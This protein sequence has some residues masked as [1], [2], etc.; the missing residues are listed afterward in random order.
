LK[1]LI[2]ALVASV[3]VAAPVVA[4]TTA[5]R[6]VTFSKDI[7][8]IL[9]RSCQRCHRPESVA[10]MTLMTYE[11]VRPYAREIKR[12]T[13]LARTPW[14]RGAMPPWFVEKN[15]GIQQFKDDVSLTDDELGKIA[16]WADSG[17]PEGDPKDLPPAVDFG[18]VTAWTLGKPDLIVSSPTVVVPASAS[19]WSGPVGRSPTNIKEDRYAKSAEYKEVSVFTSGKKPNG[20]GTIGSLYAIHH[21]NTIIDNNVDQDGNELIAEEGGEGAQATGENRQNIPNHEVGRNGD[22]FPDD[23]GRLIKK[24]SYVIWNNMHLHS[25]GVPG[26]ER[27]TRL[28]LGFKLQ[29]AGYKPKY[30]FLNIGFGRTEIQVNPSEGNQ[31]ED[32][33]FVAPQALKLQNYEPHMHATGVR[34]CLEAIYGRVIETLSCSGYDHNWVRNYY[35]DENAQPI[36][37]K[38]T[39]LHAI[40]WFD[41]TAK[42]Q[43][44][45]DPRNLTTFGNSSVSNM[46]IVFNQALPLTDEQ[47]L[48]EVAQRKAWLAKHPEQENIGCPACYLAVPQKKDAPKSVAEKR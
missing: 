14:G 2:F 47:Y 29:P 8:P 33:Y 31:R 30:N 11:Q 26:S 44:V 17:A 42:N 4:Q 35:Y 16:K 36:I 5:A 12:R 13:A 27:K 18:D 32:A 9:Q 20:A 19:D 24:G 46:F 3:L 15:I 43:N 41:N 40:S 38:G 22:V 25:A 28:D 39:I 21:M 1:R 37:P 34:M 45:L 48:D 10:P 6:P 23:A 7:A